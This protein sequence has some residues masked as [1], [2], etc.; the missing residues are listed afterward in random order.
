MTDNI[1]LSATRSPSTNYRLPCKF[2]TSLSLGEFEGK[3]YPIP[4]TGGDE[5]PL[6]V[7]YAKRTST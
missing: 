4:A 6:A 3:E 1:G 7:G 2:I 5:F